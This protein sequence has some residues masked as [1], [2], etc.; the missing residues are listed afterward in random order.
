MPKLSGKIAPR[1]IRAL[2]NLVD[3]YYHIWAGWVAR[4]W[5]VAHRPSPSP[6]WRA[7]TNAMRAACAAIRPATTAQKD[8]FKAVCT[9]APQTWADKMRSSALSALP[10]QFLLFLPTEISV[11]ALDAHTVLV[12][13]EKPANL[14]GSDQ[15]GAATYTVHHSPS[16]YQYHLPIV[17]PDPPP[18]LKATSHPNTKASWPAGTPKTEAQNIPG[19]SHLSFL[20]PYTPDPGGLAFVLST[21]DRH[22]V[23]R[24]LTG[25]VIVPMPDMTYPGAVTISDQGMSYV[26]YA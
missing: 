9:R 3:V 6:A 24:L 2:T 25:Q 19:A 4:S 21:S 12:S 20:A 14:V 26:P 13:M 5:P 1:G 16:S 18:C 23:Q 17:G 11:S 15:D 8:G 22:G 10:G 7:T